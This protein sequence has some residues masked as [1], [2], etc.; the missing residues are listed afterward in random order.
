MSDTIWKWADRELDKLEGPNGSPLDLAHLS[1]LARQ[2]Q[3]RLDEAVQNLPP[4]SP[5]V[6]EPEPTILCPTCGAAVEGYERRPFYVKH[7]TME[8][9]WEGGPLVEVPNAIPKYTQVAGVEPEWTLTPCGHQFYALEVNMES[10]RVV[11]IRDA[12]ETVIH[13]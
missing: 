12:M 2:L 11:A 13:Q 6:P 1:A 9:M 3:Y 8:P 10:G 4:V 5:A 7:G